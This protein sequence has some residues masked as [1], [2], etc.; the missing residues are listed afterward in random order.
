M[1]TDQRKVSPMQV[2]AQLLEGAL[3]RVEGKTEVP[4]EE[5]RP[6]PAD[7][8]GPDGVKVPP[9]PRARAAG[10]E[11]KVGPGSRTKPQD[12][13][14]ETAN[15]AAGGEEAGPDGTTKFKGKFV[16]GE[17]P[18]AGAPQEPGRKADRRRKKA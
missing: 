4:S 5:S 14:D 2:A 15:Q 8:A 18:K 16:H 7:R 13:S 6:D 9:V 3:D 1:S 12:A 11:T 10:K 17:V